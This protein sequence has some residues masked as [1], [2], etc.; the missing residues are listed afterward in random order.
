MFLALTPRVLTSNSQPTS[1]HHQ[2]IC[3]YH[4]LIF[5]PRSFY[6]SR[7]STA[8]KLNFLLLATIASEAI[9]ISSSIISKKD[10]GPIYP[11]KPPGGVFSQHRRSTTWAR[12]WIQAPPTQSCNSIYSQFQGRKS[13][14][15]PGADHTRPTLQANGSASLTTLSSRVR[16]KGLSSKLTWDPRQKLEL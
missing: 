12:A 2:E 4:A 10:L 8:M 1:H 16:K 13:S 14:M 7:V 11:L 15:P 3:P 5:S 9:V 6:H